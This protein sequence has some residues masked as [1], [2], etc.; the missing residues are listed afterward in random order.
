MPQKAKPH[1]PPSPRVDR[2]SPG[3]NRHYKSARWLKLRAAKLARDP[4]CEAAGCRR[5]ATDVD[6]KVALAAGGTDDM[7]GLQSLCASCHSKKTVAA[8]SGER[9]S[10]GRPKKGVER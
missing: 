3:H 6:H 5:A 1:T 10:I 8:E 7:E 2:R 9:P 4:L